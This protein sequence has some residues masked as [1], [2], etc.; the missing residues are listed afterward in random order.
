[1]TAQGRSNGIQRTIAAGLIAIY[2]LV[3]AMAA[4]PALHHWLHDDADDDGHQCAM[5]TVYQGQLDR[6]AAEA[7]VA[8]LTPVV[9]WEPRVQ[10]YA[11]TISRL[12]LVVRVLEH[13]PPTG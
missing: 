12:F 4:S 5:V 6:P 10:L 2:L 8:A 11:L 13:A 3:L 9:W 1:M 7:V